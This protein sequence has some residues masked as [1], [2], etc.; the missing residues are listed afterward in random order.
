MHAE[1]I[2][3]DENDP[4]ERRENNVD[5]RGD[6]SF[7]VRAHFLQL[8]QCLPAPLILE[9]LIREFQGMPEPVG[10]NLGAEP[11]RNRVDK[12]IL[13]ILC[14]ARDQGDSH[15]GKQEKAYP[16]KETS[17]R[18]LLEPGYV[19]VDDIPENQRIEERK[20]L[21][22]GGQKQCERQQTAVLFEI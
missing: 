15:G 3:H 14:N 22:D 19:T 11:L 1:R 18:I 2:D 12:I 20:H 10:V 9:N 5:Q 13:E 7:H 16:A 4:D 6:E 8:S 17:R 21:V